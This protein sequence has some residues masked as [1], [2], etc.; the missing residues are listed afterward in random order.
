MRTFPDGLQAHLDGGVTTLCTCWR[1]TRGDGAVYGFTDHDRTLSFDGV[2]F[3]PETGA[4]GSAL[5]SSTGLAVDNASFEG[6]L[7]AAFLT[8]A[9]LDAGRFDG[10]RIEVWRVNWANVSQRV[11]LKS[12][13]LGEVKRGP[14]AYEAELRG[15]AHVLGQTT[16]RVYQHTCDARLGDARCKIDLGDPAYFG[17][18]NV[19]SA[20]DR[21]RFRVSGLGTFDDG[22]FSL[23][24]LTWAD[25]ANAG[26][27]M[28]VK[29]HT[30]DELVLW[31]PAPETIAPGDA[32]S[33]TAGCD[34]R[35]ETCRDKFANIVNFRGFHLMPG[36]DFITGYPRRGEANDGGKR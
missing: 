5:E 2:M 23:G 35:F 8:E 3:A 1:L 20:S 33:I 13:A 16:G 6:A 11:L 36:D 32:F 27:S 26:L 31:R 34:K 21:A 28:H 24:L 29:S 15:L 22:W 10:A 18:G 7:N 17:A 25:G 19:E 9:D 14:G 30:D 4:T 12:G